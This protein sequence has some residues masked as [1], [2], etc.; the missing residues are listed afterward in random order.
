MQIPQE[1]LKAMV[2]DFQRPGRA[3]DPVLL[4]ETVE[5]TAKKRIEAP[6]VIHVKVGEKKVVNGLDLAQRQASEAAIPA[7]KKEVLH[8]L[9]GVHL[10]QE[11]VVFVGGPKNSEFDA[12]LSQR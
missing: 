10:D 12:H 2:H 1:P 7:V 11:G 3:P 4:E 8:G 5:I 6:H 9:T